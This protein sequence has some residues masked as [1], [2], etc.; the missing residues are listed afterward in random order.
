[1]ANR[2]NVNKTHS[3]RL[4]SQKEVEGFIASVISA[5]RQED[6]SS[7]A[8]LLKGC[9]AFEVERVAAL[10]RSL[11]LDS[12]ELISFRKDAFIA[13]TTAVGKGRIEQAVD[14]ASALDLSGNELRIAVSRGLKRL[15]SEGIGYGFKS[16]DNRWVVQ[17]IEGV[18]SFGL[19]RE[20][21]SGLKG[22]A[23]RATKHLVSTMS[24]GYQESECLTASTVE[25][26]V[27]AYYLT[28]ENVKSPVLSGIASLVAIGKS[29]DAL[30]IGRAFMLPIDEIEKAVL[31]GMRNV[32]V[33]GLDWRIDSYSIR[34]LKRAADIFC[35]LPES[36]RDLR[37]AA[38]RV[39]APLIEHRYPEEAIELVEMFGLRHEYV[40]PVVVDALRKS[41]SIGSID[42][43]SKVAAMFGVSEDIMAMIN[44]A[45]IN[46]LTFSESDIDK[47]NMISIKAM[48]HEGRLEDAARAIVRLGITREDLETL[49]R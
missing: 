33:R 48:V 24:S 22:I 41:I 2:A 15:I 30:D 26:F 23:I 31:K 8:L 13:V 44:G 16:T 14:L 28:Y 19:L 5:R 18:G 29:D 38:L 45:A 49:L 40:R 11:K 7:L 1:M 9:S 3:N 39:L 10:T 43:P 12:E 42:Y 27:S 32:L 46:E 34:A 36:M 35:M 37:P 4:A 17:A 20:D 25:R 47:V 21:L 6:V